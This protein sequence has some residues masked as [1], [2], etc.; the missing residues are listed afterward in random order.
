[1]VE[2][3]IQGGSVAGVLLQDAGDE[4]LGGGGERGGQVVPHLLYAPVGLIQVESLEG[5]IAAHQRVPE[6]E[7]PPRWSTRTTLAPHITSPFGLQNVLQDTSAYITQPRDHT[8]D[9]VP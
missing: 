7:T 4:F 3:L 2:D 5:G 8:S 1:M 6:R 9:S